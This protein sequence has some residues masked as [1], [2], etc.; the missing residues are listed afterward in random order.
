MRLAQAERMA[1]ALA[2]HMQPAQAVRTRAAAAGG[3]GRPTFARGEM[4]VVCGVGGHW[5]VD[6]WWSWGQGGGGGVGVGGWGGWLLMSVESGGVW[7][8]ARGVW[9]GAVLTALRSVGLDVTDKE[10]SRF[11]GRT[12]KEGVCSASSVV[13]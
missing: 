1:T 13:L 5:V 11:L 12:G 6:S 4:W 9:L 8:V 10:V 2:E 7:G 3:P